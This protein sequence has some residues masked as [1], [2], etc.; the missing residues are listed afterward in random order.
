MNNRKRSLEIRDEVNEL[1]K[2]KFGVR[3]YFSFNDLYKVK[4]GYLVRR[5][6]GKISNSLE[7]NSDQ[8]NRY[9]F[10]NTFNNKSI[11]KELNDLVVKI[12]DYLK[13]LDYKGFEIRLNKLRNQEEFNIDVI[14]SIK[15]KDI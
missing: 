11:L 14:L 6:N 8:L 13:E 3:F 15:F 5:L 2:E 4:D 10:Y 7:I 12:D 1:V 9:C